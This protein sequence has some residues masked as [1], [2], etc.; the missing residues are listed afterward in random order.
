MLED[1]DALPHGPKWDMYE[2]EIKQANGEIRMEYLF[3]RNILD[4]I[5]SLIGD[6][7]FKDKLRYAP[8]RVW[9]TKERK[10]RVYSEAWTAKWWWR[11]QVS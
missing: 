6:W 5:R 9:T 10:E 7:V 1:L 2:V 8:V 11:M 4:V 3:G